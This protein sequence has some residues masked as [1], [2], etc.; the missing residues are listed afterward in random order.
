MSSGRLTEPC[1]LAQ[2]SGRLQ[3]LQAGSSESTG[4]FVQGEGACPRLGRGPI[5]KMRLGHA[6]PTGTE[7]SVWSPECTKRLHSSKVHRLLMIVYVLHHAQASPRIRAQ[8]EPT[9]Q[10]HPD[11][12]RCLSCSPSLR[13]WCWRGHLLRHSS[14]I[15]HHCV[16]FSTTCASSELGAETGRHVLGPVGGPH[17]TE[18]L[19]AES[20]PSRIA[21]HGE[22]RGS[23]TLRETFLAKATPHPL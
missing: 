8:S 16:L 11:H 2:C 22:G 12:E 19:Q 9:R 4:H 7:T 15:S 20:G 14:M 6:A 21:K 18:M 10:E 23:R 5:K 1:Q 17:V 13:R 3:R